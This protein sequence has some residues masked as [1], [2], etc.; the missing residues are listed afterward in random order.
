MTQKQRCTARLGRDVVLHVPEVEPGLKPGSRHREVLERFGVEG[1]EEALGEGLSYAEIARQLQVPLTTMWDW[2]HASP[3]R[4]ARAQSRRRLSAHAHAQR[5]LDA[6][7]N[8]RST[9][10][11]IARAREVAQQYRW[12]AAAIAPEVYG[13][14]I[15]ITERTAS[16]VDGLRQL[17][18]QRR[19]GG[20][21]APA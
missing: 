5:A 12:A 19:A 7:L 4:S 9:P 8:A 16:V 21:D 17:E 10:T 6:L 14:K 2:I 15:Q 3:E 13:S 1:M 18:E 20:S 11:E